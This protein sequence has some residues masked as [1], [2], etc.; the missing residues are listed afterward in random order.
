MA[1]AAGRM[2]ND[3]SD[4]G[5]SVCSCGAFRLL[6]STYGIYVSIFRDHLHS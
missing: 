4:G 1:T 6:L 2:D 3:G 5:E